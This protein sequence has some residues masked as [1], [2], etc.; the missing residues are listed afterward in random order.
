VNALFK[1]A[2]DALRRTAT[3]RRSLVHG[4]VRQGLRAQRLVVQCAWCGRVSDGRGRWADVRRLSISPTH[5]TAT[6]CPACLS[7]QLERD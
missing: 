4:T 7:K 2:L 5:V 1:R 3:A 6:I